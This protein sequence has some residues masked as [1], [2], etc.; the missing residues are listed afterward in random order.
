MRKLNKIGV[1]A[2]CFVAGMATFSDISTAQITEN[3][4]QLF[5]LLQLKLNHY[6]IPNVIPMLKLKSHPV[7]WKS[8]FSNLSMMQKNLL[9]EL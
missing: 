8:Y 3:Y 5:L 4:Y 7:K 9:K 6:P 2:L 1:T